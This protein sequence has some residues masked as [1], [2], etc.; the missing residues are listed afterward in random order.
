MSRRG[1]SAGR[2]LTEA[3][4]LT[5]LSLGLALALNRLHPDALQLAIPES[6]Y[7]TISPARPL[8]LDRARSLHEAGHA[9]FLDTRLSDAFEEERIVGALS[10]PADAWD[11]RIAELEDWL[12]GAPVVVYAGTG[13]IGW[14]DGVAGGLADRGHADSLFLLLPSFEEWRQAGLP[15]ESGPD[16][17]ERLRDPADGE[18][19]GEEEEP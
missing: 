12:A 11:E 5:V 17:L 16:P 10:L 15:T 19:G 18:D 1:S 6:Y 14:A 4:V 3:L 9:V 13:Q 2:A 7:S 8:L